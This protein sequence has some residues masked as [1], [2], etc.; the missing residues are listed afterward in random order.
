MKQPEKGNALLTVSATAFA[1]LLMVAFVGPFFLVD[2]IQQDLRHV[3]EPP[4]SPNHLLGTDAL[5]RDVLSRLVS[6]ARI[7]L[8]VALVGMMGSILLGTI[9]G[10]TSG[11][12]FK[13]LAWLSDRLIDM[14]MA[15]PYVLLAIVI[16]AAVGPSIPVLIVLMILAGWPSAARVTRSIVLGERAK[17]YVRAA[18]LVGANQ[19]RILTRYIG[20][21]VVP[22]ILV[23]APLQ[24]AAMIVMEATLS[25]LGLGVQ[26]PTPSWGGILLE[27][28]PYLRD[29]WWLTTLPGLTIALTCAVLIGL[30]QGISAKLTGNRR[31]R[32]DVLRD[33]LQGE[34]SGEKIQ[35]SQE[36][37]HPGRSV[38][39]K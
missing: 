13:P 7:S 11:T 9:F 31:R 29:A 19:L 39:R 28:K 17:D 33:P 36:K 10:F 23:I 22:A 18:E 24:A 26:P 12:K 37:G 30:G 27:G 20:P 15:F 5:G 25:F 1:L 8:L 16:V 35:P 4:L 32:V 34:D 3:L 38:E 14:Q 21:T 2:P 6:G